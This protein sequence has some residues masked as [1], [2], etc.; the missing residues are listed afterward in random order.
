MTWTVENAAS[1]R[2]NHC[3]SLPLT[4]IPRLFAS[5]FSDLNLILLG[6]YVNDQNLNASSYCRENES[7]TKV[8]SEKYTD[9][10]I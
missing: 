1:L 6:E 4:V 2:W 7:L 10:D 8:K 3:V 5:L 9:R